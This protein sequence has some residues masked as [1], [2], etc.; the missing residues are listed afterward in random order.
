MK[1]NPD[2]NDANLEALVDAGLKKLPLVAAP[3]TLVKEVR[4]TL[5]E[6][7]QKPWW[8]APWWEWPWAAKFA[9]LLLALGLAGAFGGGNV[10]FDEGVTKYSGQVTER[11]APAGSAW[12]TLG[13]LWDALGLLWSAAIQPR[14][15]TWLL[16]VAGLYLIC[17]AAGAAFVR[18]TLRRV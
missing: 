10:L 6:R 17:V 12:E 8:Q 13:T 11:L 5:Q 9:F 18:T 7:A 2:P 1:P 15:L 4:R 14:L 16:V 3:P